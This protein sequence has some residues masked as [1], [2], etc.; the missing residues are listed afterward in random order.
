MTGLGDMLKLGLG[1]S[2]PYRRGIDFY[3]QGL[4]QEALEEFSVIT[5][6]EP[7]PHDLH[8]N[9]AIFYS[10]QAHCHLGTLDL[11]AGN[12]RAA[13]DHLEAAVRFNPNQFGAYHYLGMAY[14]NLGQYELSLRAFRKV[15]E[16]NPDY[17]PARTRL[18]VVLYNEA[19]YLDALAQL[20]RIVADKPLWADMRYHLGL[21][22]V[23]LGRAEEGLEDLRQAVAINPSYLKARIM[24]GVLLGYLGLSQEAI[25][26]LKEVLEERP[27]YADVHCYLGQIQASLGRLNEAQDSLRAAVSINP[28]Y[29]DA[30][31]RL[32]LVRGALGQTG[33][34][35]SELQRVLEI[36]PDHVEASQIMGHLRRLAGGGREDWRKFLMRLCQ[37]ASQRL[38]RHVDITPD[39]QDIVSV[40]SP[41]RD[42]ALY[43]S[44]IKLYRDMASRNPDF[45]DLHDN[46]GALYVRMEI[47]DKAI[48][49]FR[50]ALEVNPVYVR[51]RINL[52]RTLMS[53][54]MF[55]QAEKEI[56]LLLGQGLRFPDLYLD[57]GRA[58]KN[59]GRLDEAVTFF[60]QARELNGNLASTYWHW[61]ALEESRSRKKEAMRILESYPG[62]QG[63]GQEAEKFR[64]KVEALSMDLG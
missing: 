15:Q 46:L 14:N 40:F 36:K 52:Y 32:A 33:E 54:D 39:F 12:Y 23:S 4:Y 29:A 26:K 62:F 49:S 35:F 13:V 34:A 43:A 7:Q 16:L 2:G 24:L 11:Y 17:L 63:P 37:E 9:L 28:N 27:R 61:A 21:V 3:N 60:I 44:L 50:H 38:P 25:E 18:A 56:R 58:L 20:E 5:R 41:A 30:H 8:Y 22:K 42:R 51:P 64:A 55:G 53:L 1:L 6:L 57:L 48:E 10:G 31:L 45:A 19:R 47:Y 59:L